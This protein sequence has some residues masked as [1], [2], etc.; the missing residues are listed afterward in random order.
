MLSVYQYIGIKVVI[1]PI[2]IQINFFL[3]RKTLLVSFNRP[4]LPTGVGDGVGVRVGPMKSQTKLET[5][6]L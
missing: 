3:V 1:Y 6:L 2:F 5:N 4:D